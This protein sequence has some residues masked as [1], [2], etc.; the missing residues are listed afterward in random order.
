MPLRTGLNEQKVYF[1]KF[2]KYDS[3]RAGLFLLIH[4]LNLMHFISPEQ[5]Q[6]Y[7]EW[8]LPWVVRLA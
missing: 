7:G 3:R 2:Q 6:V 8:L 1:S 4:P 5:I